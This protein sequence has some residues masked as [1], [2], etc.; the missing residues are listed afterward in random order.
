MGMPMLPSE[1]LRLL[2]E[3]P[4]DGTTPLQD[5]CLAALALGCSN[6]EAGAM[7]EMSPHTYRRH[8]SALMT[9]V[10]VE[11]GLRP[12]RDLLAT[13]FWLH[14]EDCTAPA[15]L[16]IRRDMVARRRN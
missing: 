2:R 10:L 6:D 5:H 1:R 12:S 4:I 7:L 3:R 9:H 14:T 16:L 8:I 13:W 11:T 15:M